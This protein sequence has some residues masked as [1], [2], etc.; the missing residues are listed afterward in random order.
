MRYS[1]NQYQRD[2]DGWSFLTMASE[3]AER[4]VR[5]IIQPLI[6]GVE[7]KRERI[8]RKISAKIILFIGFVFLLYGLAILINDL[9]DVNRWV[10]F[11]LVGIIL[12]VS[13]AIKN[14]ANNH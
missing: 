2:K 5:N 1:E 12:L 11:V 8:A 10:G 9:L 6:N 7:E 13:G 14:T 3:I 4:W